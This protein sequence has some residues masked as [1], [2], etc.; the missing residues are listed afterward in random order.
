[1][2][3]R[4]LV[5]RRWRWPWLSTAAAYLHRT[6]FVGFTQVLVYVGAVAILVVFAILLT[7]GSE[8]TTQR[9]LSPAW[10]T[11]IGGG[12]A[13]GRIVDLGRQSQRGHTPDERPNLPRQSNKSATR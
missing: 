1:M 13:G 5:H 4:N 11:G 7:R 9:F 12:G 10:A 6:Q 3:P 8:P 2:S